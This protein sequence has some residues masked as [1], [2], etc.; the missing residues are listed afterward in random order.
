MTIEDVDSII[1]QIKNSFVYKNG[2]DGLRLKTLGF[3]GISMEAYK[4]WREVF[5]SLKEKPECAKFVEV[6]CP[7]CKHKEVRLWYSNSQAAWENLCGEA[8]Y[9]RICPNCGTQIRYNMILMN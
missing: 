8:G 5:E 6:K 1:R 2:S 7:V 9:I 4:P 3:H